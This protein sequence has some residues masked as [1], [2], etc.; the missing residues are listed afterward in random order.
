MS[1]SPNRSIPIHTYIS[2]AVLKK[3]NKRRLGISF[4][5]RPED[6]VVYIRRVTGAFRK[7]TDL[8]P[9][10]KILSVNG[11]N[12][13]T[14]SDAEDIIRNAPIG[15]HVQV[16]AE[17]CCTKLIKSS[18]FASCSSLGISLEQVVGRKD[19]VRVSNVQGAKQHLMLSGLQVG[20]ILISINGRS[21]T[22]VSQAKW[23][24]RLHK[25]L[26]LVSVQSFCD[27]KLPRPTL[28]QHLRRLDSQ[29]CEEDKV[30]VDPAVSLI[31]SIT[32]H[33]RFLEQQQEDQ[34]AALQQQQQKEQTYR[35]KQQQQQRQQEQDTEAIVS[36]DDPEEEVETP[37]SMHYYRR[38]QQQRQQQQQKQYYIDKDGFSVCS[39]ES[40]LPDAVLNLQIQDELRD[41]ALA[42]FL[43]GQS[44]LLPNFDFWYG[45]QQQ[46][47]RPPKNISPKIFNDDDDDTDADDLLSF[48]SKDSKDRELAVFEDT[49]LAGEVEYLTTMMPSTN[50]NNKKEEEEGFFLSSSSN[51]KEERELAAFDGTEL[52]GE[53]EEGF[54]SKS[55]NFF[56]PT[57]TT[58]TEQQEG[59]TQSQREETEE[60]QQHLLQEQQHQ[61]MWNGPEES[62]RISKEDQQPLDDDDT[63][64]V[65]EIEYMPKEGFFSKS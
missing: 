39:D 41:E 19:L 27:A 33:R 24:L 52:A 40:G 35:P 30:V 6:K 14:A 60:N 47:Q 48:L 62:K 2:G 46:Q 64:L 58:T 37:I 1:T 3:N 25:K 61:E 7:Y 17:G 44:E 57:T 59:A 54:F 53:V 12:V 5:S 32:R 11:Q 49:E 4:V 23:L 13:S 16:I 10:L 26:T 21:I 15:L 29:S 22:S 18:R 43:D 63:E 28:E 55:V 31:E 56:R 42:S 38:Q 65:G 50:N 9:C 45:E 8:V 20:S 36:D 51:S 34:R